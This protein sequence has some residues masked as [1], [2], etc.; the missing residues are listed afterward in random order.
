[1]RKKIGE[2]LQEEDDI[3]EDDV[4]DM[5]EA[6]K[7]DEFSSNRYVKQ[8]EVKKNAENTSFDYS[9]K[10]NINNRIEQENND[11]IDTRLRT[12]IVDNK[13]QKKHGFF[14][15]FSGNKQNIQK[16]NQQ[17]NISKHNFNDEEIDIDIDCYNVPSYLRKKK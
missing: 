16:D 17:K 8:K 7:Y 6:L 11:I 2:I 15:L 4:F 5:G 3:V 12:N 13:V 10:F 1:M 9:A 14:S